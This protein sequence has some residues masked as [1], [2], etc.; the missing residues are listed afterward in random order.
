MISGGIPDN[1]LKKRIIDMLDSNGLTPNK[2]LGQNFLIDENAVCAIINAADID[3]SAVLEIGP[4]LG[5]L[6]EAL[7]KRTKKLALVEIDR[8]M[9]EIL[10][11]RFGEDMLLY[12]EDFLKSDMAGICMKL[13]AGNICVV[14]NLPYYITTP[15]CMRLLERSDIISGMTLMVQEEAAARFFAAPG[16]RVYGPMSIL[17]QAFYDISSVIEL[18]PA[19][20]YPRPEV[21]SRV[22]KLTRNSQPFISSLPALL[23]NAFRMRRK[24]LVNNLKASHPDSAAVLEALKSCGLSADIRAEA[25]S[26]DDY[27]RLSAALL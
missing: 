11:R 15:I 4:G 13:G 16:S 5:S 7:I 6:T 19:S 2:A 8:D 26:S 14:G 3:G 12:R 22:V 23:H 18:S 20:Y 10:L 9:A 24:T 17:A 1:S 25:L 21:S 27:I